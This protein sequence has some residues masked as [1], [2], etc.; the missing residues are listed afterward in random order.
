M[1]HLYLFL[2]IVTTVSAA[3]ND[4]VKLDTGMISGAAGNSPEVR[5][6]KGIPFAAPPVGD[7]RWRAPQAPV[8]WEERARRISSAPCA[9]RRQGAAA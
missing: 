6:Y 4:P 1:R 5:V 3:I 2:V 8:K 7:L 9:C